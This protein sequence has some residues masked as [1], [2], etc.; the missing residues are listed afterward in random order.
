MCINIRYRKGDTFENVVN[1][2]KHIASEN[3]VVYKLV[4]SIGGIYR[5]W[6]VD[7]PI[8]YH[9]DKQLQIEHI[10]PVNIVV[11]I[12]KYTNKRTEKEL[13]NSE[14]NSF[15]N[16]K[17]Y[18]DSY[19]TVPWFV[20]KNGYFAA[21]DISYFSLNVAT[22]T[23]KILGNPLNERKPT[24]LK[25]IIPKGTVYYTELSEKQISEMPKTYKRSQIVAETLI[26]ISEIRF[27][28]YEINKS[29]KLSRWHEA[30]KAS[31]NMY[32]YRKYNE[33]CNCKDDAFVDGV[34]WRDEHPLGTVWISVND[35]LPSEKVDVLVKDEKGHKHISHRD[36]NY[37]PT[38]YAA[39][40]YY[41]NNAFV[42]PVK[43][44]SWTV[45]PD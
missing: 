26:P 8:E 31:N 32:N 36:T 22:K 43:I 25:C 42:T 4:D 1:S 6:Y 13:T 15:I 2:H 28:S 21:V 44:V 3:I 39:S 37:K 10:N 18:L 5:S 23:N 40:V 14:I 11:T 41:E 9:L 29:D 24:V 38:G 17:K 34:I 30:C 45:L 33:L 27:D 7:N 12:D 20:I 19:N 35:R 16:G